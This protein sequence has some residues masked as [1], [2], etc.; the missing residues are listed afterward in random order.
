MCRANSRSFTLAV[1]LLILLAP[2]LFA[3]GAPATAAQD[4][5]PLGV[6]VRDVT[7]GSGCSITY[8]TYATRD[9]N[10]AVA[11]EQ[12]WGCP[13]GTII[14]STP[15]ASETEAQNLGGIF[16][17]FSG[18]AETGATAVA[19]AKAQLMPSSGRSYALEQQPVTGCV[20]QGLS[21]TLS[22]WT[23][24]AGVT[25]TS[26]VYYWQDA[27]C[28]SG[29]S[30]ATAWINGQPNGDLR[31]DFANYSQYPAPF[32]HGCRTHTTSGLSDGYYV[33][34]PL[35]GLYVDQSALLDSNPITPPCSA[36]ATA[37]NDSTY[38]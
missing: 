23:Y 13:P 21:R 1:T 34:A 2:T 37:Y 28:N 38:L 22:Y 15:V 32:S 4:T 19:N 16:V 3:I 18:N 10:S 6:V 20:D 7:A 31:W 26:V 9:Y 14:E 11:D 17:P 24:A 30:S 35:G 29:I 5:L 36:W 27:F 33:Q 8:R 12:V 25:I